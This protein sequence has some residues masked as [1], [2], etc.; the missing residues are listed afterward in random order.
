MRCGA[1]SGSDKPTN[2]QKI[3]KLLRYPRAMVSVQSNRIESDTV[4]DV[5]SGKS[6]KIQKPG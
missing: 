6:P 4:N 3:A 1:Q 2:G 5:T